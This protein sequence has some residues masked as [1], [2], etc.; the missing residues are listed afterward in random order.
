MTTAT[1]TA[2]MVYTPPGGIVGSASAAFSMSIPYTAMS[3]GIL[4]VPD[5]T[6]GATE[7][8]IPFGSVDEAFALVIKNTN[9]QPMGVRLNAAV[10]VA[11]EYQIA[12][13]G[14]LIIAHPV[15][16]V[17]NELT[18]ASVTTTAGQ[19]GP[20]TIQYFVLGV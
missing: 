11:D 16:S 19:S 5:L 7:F 20:G 15:S 3:I 2:S 12:V 10:T 13:G 17:A 6:P 4:D 18:A 1:L 9:T 14:E 8:L